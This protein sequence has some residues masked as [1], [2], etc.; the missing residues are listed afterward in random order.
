MLRVWVRRGSETLNPYPYLSLP[1]PKPMRVL[2]PVIIPTYI[3]KA[4]EKINN[5]AVPVKIAKRREHAAV[6]QQNISQSI[7]QAI[8]K[9]SGLRDGEQN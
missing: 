9:D 8:R 4:E 5:L 1:Y 2:K 3:R 7:K 6:N